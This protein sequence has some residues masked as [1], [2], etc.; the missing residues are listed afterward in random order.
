MNRRDFMKTTVLAGATASL[1]RTTQAAP[2]PSERLTVGFI[3]CGARAHQHL[4]DIA[5]MSDVEVVA[6]CDAYAGR[7]ER[8]KARTGGRAVIVND[9]RE[10]LANT[11]VDA[12]FIVTPITGTRR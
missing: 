6:V 12:V 1:A 2:P 4:Q 7:A 11:A 10:I 5:S 9:Y 8:A 3:G